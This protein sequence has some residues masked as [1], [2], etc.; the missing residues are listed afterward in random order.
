MNINETT[1]WQAGQPVRTATDI[2]Q[3]Q[4]WKKERILD[5][6]RHR[7]AQYR[8]IDYY[9]SDEAMTEIEGYLNGRRTYAQ[10]I[11][12]LVLGLVPE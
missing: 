11:D 6:Q 5:G 9:P 10:I 12:A 1:P 3:W 7:R 2:A 4:A 8:R